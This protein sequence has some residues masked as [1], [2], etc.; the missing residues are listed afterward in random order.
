MVVLH[1]AQ[2]LHLF[3]QNSKE[4]WKNE[5]KIIP[6]RLPRLPS[7][8]CQQL[9]L[10][11]L[12]SNF[13][14]LKDCRH[15]EIEALGPGYPPSCS[16]LQLKPNRL[17]RAQPRLFWIDSSFSPPQ[18]GCWMAIFGAPTLISHPKRN[19]LSLC[20]HLKIFRIRFFMDQMT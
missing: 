6:P 19:Q 16:A 11:K 4:S 10:K 20:K 3:L 15:C 9:T 14:E 18:A 12:L 2:V 7:P 13:V 17:V 1:L 5:K 8:I